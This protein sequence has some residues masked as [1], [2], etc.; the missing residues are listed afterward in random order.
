M[1][2]VKKPRSE[3]SKNGCKECKRRKIKCDEFRN[4]PPEAYRKINKQ[5]RESCW[6]CTRLNKECIYPVKGEK[7]ARVSRK[8]LMAERRND[9]LPRPAPEVYELPSFPSFGPTLAPQPVPMGYP[10]PMN[11]YGFMNGHMSPSHHMVLGQNGQALSP[12]LQNGHQ[13]IPSQNVQNGSQNGLQNGIGHTLNG[14]GGPTPSVSAPTS[15]AT[16]AAGLDPGG[17]MMGF[18]TYDPQDLT[19][20]ASDLNNLVLDLMYDMDY[21]VKPGTDLDR[22]PVTPLSDGAGG[23]AAYDYIPRNVPMEYVGPLKKHEQLF[24]HEFYHEFAQYILPFSLF[25]NQ[26]GVAF[27]P[28]RDVI[29]KCAAKEP[30]LL[31]AVLAQGARLLAAKHGRSDDDEAYFA[32]LLR[33]LKLLGP[34][35]SDALGKTS[36]ALTLNVEAVLLTVLL[37]T[38]LN[39]VTPKQNWRPHLKGAKDLLL[40]HSR[41]SLTHRHSKV[42]VFCRL[43][44]VM[45]EV[46]TGIGSH[47]GGTVKLDAE[48][49]LLLNYADPSERRILEDMGFI[50][51]NGFYLLGGYHNDTIF[52]LRDLIKLLNKKRAARAAKRQ[53]VPADVAEYIRLLGVFEQ[54]RQIEFHSRRCL[55]P[56][57]AQPPGLTDVLIIDGVSHVLLWPDLAQQMTCLAA[58]LVLLTD[59]LGLPANAPQVQALIA[60]MSP[61]FALSNNYPQNGSLRYKYGILMLQW[62]ALVAGLRVLTQAERLNVETFFSAAARAGAGSAPH[63]LSRLRNLWAGGVVDES[64]DVVI[65]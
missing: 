13:M 62:P 47:L 15:G 29:L 59:F 41:A 18:N 36:M 38:S 5:G 60:Q 52:S 32:Y 6:H 58:L 10:M 1:A 54:Q 22:T 23:S 4:P 11:H 51:P 53:F 61:L 63:T 7:V 24:L 64:V 55:Y 56:A 34:A 26:S 19:L 31:A 49:D 57:T 48:L 2:D 44:F 14:H 45:F 39:A 20:L 40:K 43:W 30:F 9:D 21:D 42:L 50:L 17:L 33:C 46:L 28:V 3:Y 27:N 25:D 35:L 65:Y 16:L 8:V 37:L 12:P